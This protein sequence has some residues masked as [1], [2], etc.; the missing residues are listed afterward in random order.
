MLKVSA[1]SDRVFDTPEPTR[2]HIFS[3]YLD[4]RYITVTSHILRVR[5]FVTD[6]LG[7]IRQLLYADVQRAKDEPAKHVKSIEMV[8]QAEGKEG[9]YVAIGEWNLLGGFAE[10]SEGVNAEPVRMV[11]GAGIGTTT[12][13]ERCSN[14]TCVRLVFRSR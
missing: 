5:Q 1:D 4:K 11:A 9:H 10:E 2:F 14:G 13:F 3:R 7:N 6:R 12:S 8:P